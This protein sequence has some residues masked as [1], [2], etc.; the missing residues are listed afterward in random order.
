MLWSG[1]VTYTQG[2]KR[3]QKKQILWTL[4]YTDQ[5]LYCTGRK[6]NLSTHTLLVQE[7]GKVKKSNDK[8]EKG[9]KPMIFCNWL[10]FPWFEDFDWLL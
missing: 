4:L 6:V 8:E 10:K 7:R 9:K 2:K 1:K 5:L 3:D